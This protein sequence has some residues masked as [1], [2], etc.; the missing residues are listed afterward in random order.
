MLGSSH[1]SYSHHI[2][3]TIFIFFVSSPNFE[4]FDLLIFMNV[5]CINFKY[6]QC[7]YTIIIPTEAKKNDKFIGYKECEESVKNVMILIF[8]VPSSHFFVPFPILEYFNLLIFMNIIC[9]NLKCNQCFQTI[10]I[11]IEV[12]KK[13]KI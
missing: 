10:L 2:L 8:L 7:L 9:I 13:L 4:Y 3:R 11:P 1:F 12:K 5:I 6:N